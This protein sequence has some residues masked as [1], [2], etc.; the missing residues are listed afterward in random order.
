MLGRLLESLAALKTP[1]AADVFVVI[2]D[3]D[4]ARSAQAT[5]MDFA[6]RAPWPVVYEV[7]DRRG[8]PTSRNRAIAT[9]LDQ[10]ADFVAFVDDDESV[11]AD[12]L[13]ELV[14]TQQERHL[15]LVGG[16]VRI[17]P[18]VVTVTRWQSDILQGIAARY[19][20][21]E[22]AAARKVLRCVDD[23]IVIVT[24]NWLADARW[25]RDTGLRFDERMLLTG[26]TDTLFY[27][28]AKKLGARTGWSPSAAVYE[29]IPA[30]RLRF[31]YQAARARDQVT[32][33]FHRKYTRPGP[34]RRLRAVAVAAGKTVAA[35]VC[36]LA[37]PIGGGV[38]IVQSARLIGGGIGACPRGARPTIDGISENGRLLGRPV[39]TTVG[40]LTGTA[41]GCH[42]C[43]WCA[44]RVDRMVVGIITESS[45]VLHCR[46]YRQPEETPMKSR[47]PAPMGPP[48]P[49][50]L[51]IGYSSQDQPPPDWN[52]EARP[53]ALFVQLCGPG[54]Y[55]R[56]RDGPGR[57]EG[58]AGSSGCWGRRLLSR[59]VRHARDRVSPHGLKPG[60]GSANN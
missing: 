30:T 56:G 57:A 60:L 38:A 5:V 14:R 3:N 4:L 45:C 32:A 27:Y 40:K 35:G 24:N 48:P 13:A 58:Y 9:A 26:G 54:G 2:V 12:W 19:A 8:I 23:E 42:S 21:K 39:A 33:G 22:K 10:H 55:V 16:P 41:P 50:R 46:I 11:S 28:E 47:C 52:C 17:A 37:V 7:E 20:R 15:Q 44:H 25:L 18:D 31:R 43:L 59:Q 1:P 49:P 51:P 29:S 53:A 34:L 6:A 36:L